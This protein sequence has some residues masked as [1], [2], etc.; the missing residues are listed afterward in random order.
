MPVWV[1][2]YVLLSYGTGAIMAVPAHDERDF[3]F[4][5]QFN[6]SIVPVVGE[7]AS[8]AAEAASPTDECFTGEGVAINSDKYDGLPTIEFKKRIAADLTKQGLGRNAVNY[9]LRDWLFSRQRFWGEPFP[10]LHELDANGKP[11]G[12]VRAVD[13][14]DLPVDLPHLEDFKPHGRPEPP[15]DKAPKEWLYP[16]IDGKRYK[17]ETNTMPQWAGSCWY[18]LRFLDP[19]NKRAP[20]DP[21]IEKA[22]MPVDL[23]VGGAEHAVLHLLLYPFFP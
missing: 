11:T 2:D 5:K 6:L 17:R 22:W 13:E 18:Y 9:K 16:T 21:E 7:A 20:I 15:L 12:C 1:A 8:A 10:I 23:Y 14:K 4:A 19:T 3:E